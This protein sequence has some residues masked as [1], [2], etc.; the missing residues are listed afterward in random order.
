MIFALIVF[1][2]MGVGD[3]FST[4]KVKFVVDGHHVRAD[5][6]EALS[7]LAQL[8]SVGVGAVTIFHAAPLIAAM[9]LIGL[10]CGSMIGTEI[11]QRLAQK[12]DLKP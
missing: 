4:A 7:D 5:I 1:L 3:I 8:G 9:I 10:V 2:S 6:C 12:W 11:G